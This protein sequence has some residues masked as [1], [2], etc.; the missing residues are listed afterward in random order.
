MSNR[1][2]VKALPDVEFASPNGKSL[3]LDLY[4]PIGA[5][6]PVP[7]IVWLHG[8]GWRIGDRKLGPEFK[9]RFA[10]R[11]YAMASIEYRLSGEAIFPAQIHDVKAAIRWLRSVANEYGLDSKH[12]GL[13]GSSAGGHLAALAGT[14]GSGRLED[15]KLGNWEYFSDVQAVVDGYGPTDFLQMEEYDNSTAASSDDPESIRLNAVQRHTDPDSPESQLLGAPIQ[16]VP[17]L[18]REANPITYIDENI[19]PFLI[20]HGLSDTAVPVHQSELLYQALIE[21][22]NE[23]ALCLIEGMGHAFFNKNGLDELPLQVT[24]RKAEA[25]EP[26][27]IESSKKRIFELVESFFRKHLH[28]N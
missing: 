13:W 18:V 5:E 9:V 26:E 4:L 8:G 6:G 15:L 3:L 19:P 22:G 27:Q 2:E 24:L 12:I 11:G 7:V 16:T 23:A 10:E 1:Y 20:L 14:T 21:H 28:E 25:G 17:N